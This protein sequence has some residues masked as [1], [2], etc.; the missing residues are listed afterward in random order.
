MTTS[1][2]ESQSNVKWCFLILM[3]DGKRFYSGDTEWTRL[4]DWFLSTS[5]CRWRGKPRMWQIIFL[6]LSFQ[7]ISLATTYLL[8]VGRLTLWQF[9]QREFIDQHFKNL[10]KYEKCQ[11]LQVNMK[12]EIVFLP[13]ACGMVKGRVKYRVS[14]SWK[15]RRP[16][17][18]KTLRPLLGP[19]KPHF[20]FSKS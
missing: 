12:K 2:L 15:R 8:L 19:P 7:F 3:I 13:A 11:N 20:E 5:N 17:S 1:A 9:E 18:S 10:L 14:T 6:L 4:K 16:C